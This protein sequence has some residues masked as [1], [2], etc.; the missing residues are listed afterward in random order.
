MTKYI[1]RCVT[2]GTKIDLQASGRNPQ[3]ALDNI[4]RNKF[5]RNAAAY[6]VFERK[7]GAI[8]HTAVNAHRIK[9]SL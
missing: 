9:W 8:V 5:A 7:S 4:A 6:V 2:N 1:V 3:R